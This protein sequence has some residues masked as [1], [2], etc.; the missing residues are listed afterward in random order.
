MQVKLS[1]GE[2]QKKCNE[3]SKF[4]S[5][6]DQDWNILVSSV[7]PCKL[8]LSLNLEPYQALI[9][10]VIFQQLRP[11]SATAIFNKF[12]E[13]FEGNYPTAKQ[14]LNFPEEKLKACGLSSNKLQTIIEIS[15][16]FEKKEFKNRDGFSIMSDKQIIEMLSNIKG[17]GEWSAQMLMIF[18]LGK[19]DVFPLNDF[20]LKKNYLLFKN[21]SESINKKEFDKISQKWKPYRSI[22]AWYLWGYKK[23]S[24]RII[25]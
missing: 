4:L 6:L 9:K 12:V 15:N 10:S 18:N 19:L 11:S 21:F 25:L 17:I 2:H 22:A 3:G 24:R 5:S 13:K 20:A 14:I 7:G 1:S 23:A 16:Q 8:N